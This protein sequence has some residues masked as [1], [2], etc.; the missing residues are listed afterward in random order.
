MMGDC[1]AGAVLLRGQR[2]RYRW[3]TCKVQVHQDRARRRTVKT[4][5][6]KT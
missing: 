3:L 5:L 4:T 1:L 6:A 2:A